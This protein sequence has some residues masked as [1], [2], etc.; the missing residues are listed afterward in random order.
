METII[1]VYERGVLRPLTRLP[2]AEHTHVRLQIVEQ[3]D[4]SDIEHPLMALAG[5]G[6][7]AEVDVSERAEDIL[8]DEVQP[9]TGWS[10]PDANPR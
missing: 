3:V 10:A 1:A 9:D 5:L 7:S 6:T 2:L 4:K 8:A